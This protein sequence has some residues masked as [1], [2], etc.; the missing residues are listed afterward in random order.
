M[1]LKIRKNCNRKNPQFG[2][3]SRAERRRGTGSLGNHPTDTKVRL[4]LSSRKKNTERRVTAERVRDA[5]PALIGAGPKFREW[6]GE[7]RAFVR[8]PDGDESGADDA[9][10]GAVDRG[11]QA[12]RR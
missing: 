5:P 1:S 3:R 10:P 12:R 7:F 8:V 6:T 2:D 4:V 9:D 11:R